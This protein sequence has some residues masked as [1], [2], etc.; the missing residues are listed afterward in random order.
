MDLKEWQKR[1]LEK[2]ALANMDL[3]TVYYTNP[4]PDERLEILDSIIEKE[5]ESERTRIM[6]EL[7]KHRYVSREKNIS[8][9]DYAI[10]GWVN[11]SFIAEMMRGLFARK[12]IPQRVQ[13]ILE[14][15][16]KNVADRNGELGYE[17]WLK[18]IRNVCRVYIHLCKTDKAY[19]SIIFGIG[20]MKKD[21]LVR[22]ICFDMVN[23]THTIPREAGIKELDFLAQ[24]SREVFLEEFPD[25]GN[26]YDLMIDKA[27]GKRPNA[28]E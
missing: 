26:L 28:E 5:G 16:G 8:K 19:G 15:L 27:D 2:I 24:A 6:M 3:E 10:R 1:E 18:D 21:K 7:Y 11:I 12:K 13:E 22:K 14:D 25:S 17:L 4:D 9:I 20:R 23:I